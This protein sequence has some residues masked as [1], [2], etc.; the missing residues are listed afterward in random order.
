MLLECGQQPLPYCTE[1]RLRENEKR[2]EAVQGSTSN[3]Q[4]LRNQTDWDLGRETLDFPLR[5]GW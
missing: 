5:I 4:C 2:A 1:R 3:V